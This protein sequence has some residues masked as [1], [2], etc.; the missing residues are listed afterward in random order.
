METHVQC[1]LLKGARRQTV[2][3]PEKFAVVGKY[4]MIKG[5]QGWEDG[6]KVLTVGQKRSTEKVQEQSDRVHKG[7]FG[8]IKEKISKLAKAK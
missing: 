1:N 8:S 6:W 7:I 3:I 5:D 4:I 2:W